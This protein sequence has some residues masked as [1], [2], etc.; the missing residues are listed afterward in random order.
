MK[1]QEFKD[2]SFFWPDSKK[3]IGFALVN[4]SPYKDS[5]LFAYIDNKAVY[6]DFTVNMV[7]NISGLTDYTEVITKTEEVYSI[8]EGFTE[9]EQTEYLLMLANHDICNYEILSFLLC[10]DS[11]RL[12]QDFVYYASNEIISDYQLLKTFSLY[13]SPKTEVNLEKQIP[14]ED[15]YPNAIFK[16]EKE[17]PTFNYHPEDNSDKMT[18]YMI[19]RSDIGR[20]VPEQ[21]CDIALLMDRLASQ[22]NFFEFRDEWNDQIVILQADYEDLFV[23]NFIPV[24]PDDPKL[25]FATIESHEAR[26]APGNFRLAEA[27]IT[28]IAYMGRKC[29]MPKFVRKLETWRK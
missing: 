1:R 18:V 28:G 16:G 13:Y 20:T 5:Y 25:L 17:M 6:E 14:L 8:L 24:K 11:V 22:E 12:V 19:L 27:Q 10:P 23:N 21:M 3:G 26:V 9:E 15:I 2:I 29:D 4:K 7:M